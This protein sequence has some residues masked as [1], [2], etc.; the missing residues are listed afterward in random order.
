MFGNQRQLGFPA[1]WE[2]S[3]ISVF[4]KVLDGD[5]AA[6]AVTEVPNKI[7]PAIIP[8]IANLVFL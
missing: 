3:T 1:S 2:T 8:R 5:K 6:F 4:G 7:P